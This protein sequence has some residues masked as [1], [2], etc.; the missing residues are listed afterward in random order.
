VLALDRLGRHRNPAHFTGAFLGVT[1]ALCA[2]GAFACS[3]AGP[4][5]EAWLRWLG[6]ML[7]RPA[8]LAALACQ[9]LLPTVLAFHW[10]N[11]Y[12][13]RV[14]PANAALIYLLEPV[15]T[16]ALS[17]LLGMDRLTYPLI[18]GGLLIVA[19]NCLA[20]LPG[21]LARRKTAAVAAPAEARG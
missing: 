2:A 17:A 12:Q 7:A 3:A 19:G 13:P 20:A 14:P 1:G 10:M 8:V 11:T 9:T 16:C 15:F 5:Q 18:G 6:E 4:G 21:L